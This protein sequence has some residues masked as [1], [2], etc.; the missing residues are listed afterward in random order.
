MLLKDSS[1]TLIVVLALTA[2]LC[3]VSIATAFIVS[4]IDD[5]LTGR[6]LRNNTIRQ[7]LKDIIT[8]PGGA[9]N[10]TK[11]L[12][13]DY[14]PPGR[15]E[16]VTTYRRNTVENNSAQNKDDDNQTGCKNTDS[17]GGDTEI[18]VWS[19]TIVPD[20]SPRRQ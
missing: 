4:D 16:R 14:D 11:P 12:E 5:D 1:R 7:L 18:P 20:A 13:H 17:V 9:D 15:I 6:S 10:D 19:T 3:V 2:T 8:P